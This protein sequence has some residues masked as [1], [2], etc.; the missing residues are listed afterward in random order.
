M[1]PTN[2]CATSY[3]FRDIQSLH[4]Y[5]QK[6]GEGHGV[7]F[8]QI[9]HLM[10]TVKINK[11]LPHV[12]ALALT[13]FRNIKMYFFLPSKCRSI[14]QSTIIAITSFDGNCQY[15]QMSPDIFEL[16]LPFQRYKKNKLLTFKK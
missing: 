8:S 15:L 12:S 2:F 11:C 5:L 3:R 13:R 7:Q 4:F 9:H 16:L 14:S 1:S 10:A 6:V